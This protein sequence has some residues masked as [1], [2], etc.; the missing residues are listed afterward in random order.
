MTAKKKEL[1]ELKQKII[2]DTKDHLIDLGIYK[3]YKDVGIEIY[4]QSVID[5]QKAVEDAEK[6]GEVNQSQNGMTQVNAYH[7]Q[8]N[9]YATQ[10][11]QWEHKLFSEDKLKGKSNGSPKGVTGLLQSRNSG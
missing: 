6:H 11:K 4:A 5:W 8:K 2:K 1:E 7:T 3:P 10:V 9:H